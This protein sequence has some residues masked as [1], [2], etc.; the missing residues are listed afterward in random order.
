VTDNEADSN[1]KTSFVTVVE[2]DESTQTTI[3]L[4]ASDDAFISSRSRNK[5]ENYDEHKDQLLADASDRKF[6]SMQ[7]LIKWDVSSIESCASIEGASI[8]L[9]VFNRSPGAYT[10]FAGLNEW[11]ENTVTWNSV[12]GDAHH[13]SNIGSFTPNETKVF[14]ITLNAAGLSAIQRWLSGDNHGVVIASGGTRNGIDI[15]DR[16]SALKGSGKAPEITLTYNLD[17]CPN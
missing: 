16:E 15:H 3:T 9:D 11:E 1:S 10:L 13:G 5:D 12:D 7:T 17:Q 2:P 14:S 4:Q 6:G 8:E